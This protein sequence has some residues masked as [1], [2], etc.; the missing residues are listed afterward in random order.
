MFLI[1]IKEMKKII[2]NR[3][4]IFGIEWKIFGGLCLGVFVL[5]M[6]CVYIGLIK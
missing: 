2:I 5:G 6:L 3:M 1:L 4:E